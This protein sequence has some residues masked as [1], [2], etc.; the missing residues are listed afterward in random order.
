MFVKNGETSISYHS[1]NPQ[2]MTLY[3]FYKIIST[4]DERCY[5]GQTTRSLTVRFWYHKRRTGNRGRG[6]TS[7]RVLFIDNGAETCSIE[8]IE[9]KEMESK[10]DALKH[11]RYLIENNNCVNRVRPYRSNEERLKQVKM[12]HI[13]NREALLT[14]AREYYNNHKEAKISAQRTYD[15]THKQE[16]D[17][18]QAQRATC[19]ICGKEILKYGLP[20]HIRSQHA[21]L[22]PK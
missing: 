1:I 10:V 4:T 14:R 18:R 20:R 15:A 2:V 16:H 7:S 8:L 11:E 17:R 5:I 6:G 19:D 9:E 12:Y 3:R 21:Q 13:N 22:I